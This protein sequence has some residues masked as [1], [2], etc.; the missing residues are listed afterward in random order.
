MKTKSNM[1][2]KDKEKKIKQ[3]EHES[4][5]LSKISFWLVKFISDYNADR[6][7]YKLTKVNDDKGNILGD[8]ELTIKKLK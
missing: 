6:F 7:V 1:T 4:E 3:N 2:D 8:F 5:M